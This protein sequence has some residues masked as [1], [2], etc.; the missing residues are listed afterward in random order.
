MSRAVRAANA[1]WPTTATDLSTRSRPSH[2][3]QKSTIAWLAHGKIVSIF[4]ST[5]GSG[6]DPH[7]ED[8][9]ATAR[10]LGL[11]EPIERHR[12]AVRGL[13]R[14]KSPRPA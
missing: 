7:R 11:L 5:A 9:G 6:D 1:S 2:R 10:D 13:L 8:D 14:R 12:E 4:P 3:R